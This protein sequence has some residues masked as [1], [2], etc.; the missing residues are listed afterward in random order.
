[1]VLV[2]GIYTKAYMYITYIY[3]STLGCMYVR[4]YNDI[5][6][7]IYALMHVYIVPSNIKYRHI[8]IYMHI[9]H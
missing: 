1:M 9:M 5:T 4:A 7:A 2:M 3:T 6:A 8:Y